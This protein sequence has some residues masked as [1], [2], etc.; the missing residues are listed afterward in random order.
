[1]IKYL[2]YFL[3][4]FLFT[5][6]SGCSTKTEKH[7]V[8]STIIII[9]SINVPEKDK[10]VSE[11]ITLYSK[12][13]QEQMERVLV[14]SKHSMKKGTPEGTLNNFVADLIL[15]K[16]LKLYKPTE[17]KSIDFCLLNYGGLRTSIPQGKVTL[18]R[19]FELMPFENEMVVV[20]IN[21]EKTY[22]LFKYLAKSEYGMPV[23]AVRLGIKDDYPAIIEIDGEPFDDTRNYKILTSDYLAYG[24]DN[25]FFFLQPISFEPVGIKVRDAIIRYMENMHQKGAKI[26]SSLNE[27]IFYIH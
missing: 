9:D 19:I 25:M 11:K 1:M 14:Y 8:D 4:L 10:A 2:K 26:S 7:V 23:S 20:T 12:P 16:G 5:T 18:G 3:A 27:R 21:P 13:L 15:E 17:N 24:G 22:E 6:F